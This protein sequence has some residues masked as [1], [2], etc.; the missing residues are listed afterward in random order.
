MLNVLVVIHN[1]TAK[2]SPACLSLLLQKDPDA[3]ILLYDNSE[4]DYGLRESCKRYGWTYLGGQGNLGLPRAYN[5]AL[6]LLRQEGDQGHLCLLDDD[7]DLPDDFIT[8]VTSETAKDPDKLLFPILRQGEK[9]LSPWTEEKTPR[10][11]GTE[12]ECLQAEG[13][14][15][16]AFNSGM[17]IPLKAV[18][19][20]RYDERLFLDCVDYS[21]LRDMKRRGVTGKAIPVICRQHF[22]GAERP[23]AAAAMARFSIYTRDMRIFWEEDPA[24]GEKILLKRALHLAVSY[25]SL[26]PL[27]I[28]FKS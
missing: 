5:A 13:S 21:F 24:R 11:F 2:E 17:L 18:R 3:R 9:I 28:L 12:E 27:G 15:L 19:D 23:P 26:R 6:D 10:F 8:S 14:G 16:L 7:T 4:G 22:S 1:R 25:C 20:Y